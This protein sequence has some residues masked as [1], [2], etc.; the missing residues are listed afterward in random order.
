MIFQIVIV[1]REFRRINP[2]FNGSLRPK[3][4]LC[5]RLIQVRNSIPIFRRTSGFFQL[6]EKMRSEMFK[7]GPHWVYVVGAS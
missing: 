1:H 7:F 2:H 6:V 3:N 5:S 4:D